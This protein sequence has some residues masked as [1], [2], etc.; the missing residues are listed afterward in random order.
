MIFIHKLK[1][2]YI[3]SYLKRNK[4][5]KTE[6]FLHVLLHMTKCIRPTWLQWRLTHGPAGPGA[7]GHKLFF[8]RLHS[9]YLVEQTGKQAGGLNPALTWVRAPV[10]RRVKTPPQRASSSPSSSPSTGSAKLRS[11]RVSRWAT[12][13]RQTASV[14]SC[15]QTVTIT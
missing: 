7:S 12:P 10:S 11:P 1:H 15:V 6:L 3:M 9:F 2:K 4:W 5:D 14:P 8:F 13:H